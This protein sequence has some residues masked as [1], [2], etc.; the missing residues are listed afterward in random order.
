MTTTFQ[1]ECFFTD[2]FDEAKAKLRAYSRMIDRP[3]EVRYDPYTQMVNVLEN[4]A[5][6]GQVIG[7]L[8]EELS[9][10]ACALGKV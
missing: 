8:Q 3:F 7:K 9:V 2:T 4:P 6:I 5:K 10:L 1:N